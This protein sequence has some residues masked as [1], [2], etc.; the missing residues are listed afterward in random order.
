MNDLEL[1]FLVLAVVYTWECACW[2]RRG[3]VVFLTWL[4]RR[5]RAVHPGTV[6]GNQHGGFVF[7][8]P[9]PPLGTVLAG[10]PFPLSLSPEGVLAY[11]APSVKPEWRPVQTGR[12]FRFAD[13]RDTRA[14]G[15]RVLVNGELLLRVAPPR[16]ALYIAN[17]LRELNSLPIEKRA[18]RIQA[19]FRGHFDIKA[20]ETRRR[21]FDERS[22]A[23]RWA[24]NALFVYLFVA[25]PVVISYVGL[26]ASWIALL[27]GLLALTTTSAILFRRAHL[28]LY[29]DA[30]EE[31]FSQCL[32]I[33]LSPVT[34]VRARDAL[35]RPLLETFHPLAIA[36]VLCSPEEVRDT[37]RQ[38]LLETRFPAQPACPTTSPGAESTE[39]QSREVLLVV[40]E[41][42]LK[43][44]KI[45]PEE[46]IKPPT[47]LD[48]SCLAYCPRCRT[49]FTA[50]EGTCADCG[51][52][53]LV[54]FDS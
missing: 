5:W 20:I 28:K 48:K 35:S 25:A 47:P 32:T 23:L 34:A 7:A 40:V 33:L 27:A 14:K 17:C 6:L 15:N 22:R 38:T 10:N 26:R 44:N 9:F 52:L 11:V 16:F 54:A 4:G 21:E 41:T 1:L 46:L 2:A 36:Q 8:P 49:Q 18:D 3:S 30:E 50:K 13:I 29:P 51:G 39:Q 37:A 12:F 43:E 42:F 19:V 45:A 53:A 31:R 24:G